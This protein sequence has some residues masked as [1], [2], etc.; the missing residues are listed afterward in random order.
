MAKK[1]KNT[2]EKTEAN[3]PTLQQVV[4][5]CKEHGFSGSV[6]GKWVWLFFEEKPEEAIRKLLKDFG[7][8]WSSRR[9]GWAHNCGHPVRSAAKSS[10]FDKYQMTAI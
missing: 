7:F 1:Q 8:R 5:F 2:A 6:V 10:P 9:G 4:D 3:I